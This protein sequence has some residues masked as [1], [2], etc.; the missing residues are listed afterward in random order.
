LARAIFAALGR[1][2]AIDFIPMPEILR[3][4]YQY[5]T[6]ADIGKLRDSGYTRPM[7]PL[8]AAVKDY[9]ANYLVPGRKLGEEK[10]AP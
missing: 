7:T 9:V 3:D 10:S 1:E 5:Y 2:P 6:K 4:K 8:D